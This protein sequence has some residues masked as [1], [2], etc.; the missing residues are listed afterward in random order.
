MGSLLRFF[1][2][3]AFG[4]LGA[5]AMAA[6]PAGEAN[7][8]QKQWADF[9][10]HAAAAKAPKTETP[11]G[12]KEAKGDGQRQ[13][14]CSAAGVDTAIKSLI[15]KDE[16]RAKV[17]AWAREIMRNTPEAGQALASDLIRLARKVGG[18]E[19]IIGALIQ[20]SSGLD[21]GQTRMLLDL[22]SGLKPLLL[23]GRPD[24]RMDKEADAVAAGPSDIATFFHV[25]VGV[26]S[27]LWN[28]A[29]IEA[30]SVSD[31]K[32]AVEKAIAEGEKEKLTASDIRVFL[33]SS[34]LPVIARQAADAVVSEWI[35]QDAV[36]RIAKGLGELTIQ[37]NL[38][39]SQRLDLA[40]AVRLFQ[41]LNFFN[42]GD[43]QKTQELASQLANFAEAHSFPA[44][45]PTVLEQTNADYCFIGA[46]PDK[47]RTFVETQI[48]DAIKRIAESM[49]LDPKRVASE[50]LY[51]ALRSVG[52]MPASS[53]EFKKAVYRIVDGLRNGADPVR[54]SDIVELSQR[55]GIFLKPEQEKAFLKL[56]KQVSAGDDGAGEW[57]VA[58]GKHAGAEARGQVNEIRKAIHDTTDLASIPE[59]VAALVKAAKDFA[60][61]ASLRKDIT[62]DHFI[63][64]SKEASELGA[65][66]LRAIQEAWALDTLDPQYADAVSKLKGSA[67]LD[68]LAATGPVTDQWKFNAEKAVDLAKADPE[69]KEV[70]EKLLEKDFFVGARE[71]ELRKMLG[72]KAPRI[73][74]PT[75]TGKTGASTQGAQ[76]EAMPA[77]MAT[78]PT[79][80]GKTAEASQATAG[81]TGSS[82]PFARFLA[83]V[84]GSGKTHADIA[85]FFGGG[86]GTGKTEMPMAMGPQK[87]DLVETGEGQARPVMVDGKPVVFRS[88]NSATGTGKTMTGVRGADGMVRPAMEFTDEAAKQV[89]TISVKSPDGKKV[90]EIPTPT[91]KAKDL[92]A[93]ISARSITG[94][95]LNLAKSFLMKA[96]VDIK[97]AKQLEVTGYSTLPPKTEMA[98]GKKDETM[99][100]KKEE[101]KMPV[102]PADEAE[103][104]YA[105]ADDLKAAG[106][107]PDGHNLYMKGALGLEKVNH[108]I[109]KNVATFTVNVGDEDY[110]IP[111]QGLLSQAQIKAAV[112]QHGLTGPALKKVLAEIKRRDP[113]TS[114][115]GITSLDVNEVG[116][117]GIMVDGAGSRALGAVA[118]GKQGMLKDK[119]DPNHFDAIRTYFIDKGHCVGLHDRGPE[120]DAGPFDS[121]EQC[122]LIASQKNACDVAQKMEMPKPS[123]KEDKKMMVDVEDAMKSAGKCLSCHNGEH[124]DRPDFRL[125]PKGP[126]STPDRKAILAALAAH[127]GKD[128]DKNDTFKH[129]TEDD[130]NAN[131]TPAQVKNFKA[132]LEQEM[133][134]P[135][136]PKMDDQPKM[137]S[138]V[139]SP[140]PIGQ[141]GVPVFGLDDHGYPADASGG[142]NIYFD[143]NLPVL[144]FSLVAVQGRDGRSYYYLT[145]RQGVPSRQP[146]A[147]GTAIR[148]D[149]INQSRNLWYQ[150]VL[151]SEGRAR[152]LPAN[153]PESIRRVDLLHASGMSWSRTEWSATRTSGSASR[154]GSRTETRFCAIQAMPTSASS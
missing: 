4:M 114:T 87:F 15:P 31:L 82:N 137:I 124:A 151:D 79:G 53:P 118:C 120:S 142:K 146:I 109:S 19:R 111:V 102:R 43:A 89:A 61:M 131:L 144:P 50:D 149:F 141:Q 52:S 32:S 143:Q 134:Q 64:S 24:T 108:D 85:K 14:A 6:A 138:S 107:E 44:A 21:E 86:T 27:A 116:V 130:D 147:A 10:G 69:V 36:L 119:S 126:K 122:Q 51:H 62:S 112:A 153:P 60:D 71:A 98:E 68:Y 57:K 25:G 34:K 40:K 30:G 46:V 11:S 95:L 103:Y 7:G 35:N 33:N 80:S 99:P 22:V 113:K 17:Q 76:A 29:K 129:M 139:H 72:V 13:L 1:L 101:M 106:I 91:H 23:N 110:Q 127:G 133:S 100:G 2:G 93:I 49:G 37:R 88:R 73:A 154:N 90:V 47:K 115:D 94:A 96:G 125:E 45:L 9:F 39:G 121:L 75:G 42:P 105:T 20:P 152:W 123:D 56:V 55:A 150:P 83:G 8:T 18:A 97:D 145:N 140:V 84:T 78:G 26:A 92:S 132:W 12:R 41:N 5:A 135:E 104:T 66:K 70:L 128:L 58:D 3:V 74:G 63:L 54:Y 77:D 117:S 148:G 81:K 136:P 48:G 65:P 28:V 59:K 38:S 16:D 67:P